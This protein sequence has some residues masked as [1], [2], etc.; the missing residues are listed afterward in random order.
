MICPHC[1]G[2]G[3]VKEVNLDLNMRQEAFSYK[4][5]RACLEIKKHV[6]SENIEDFTSYWT[7]PTHAGKKM[8]FELERTWDTKRRLQTWIRNDKKFNPKKE[9]TTKME[10]GYLDKDNPRWQER[11]GNYESKPK[12]ISELIKK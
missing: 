1:Q 10:S 8:R 12:P 5:I 9:E 3:K 11:T 7:E 6:T 2:T 4:V